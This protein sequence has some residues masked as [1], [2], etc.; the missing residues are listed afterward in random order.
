MEE[1]QI[2]QLNDKFLGQIIKWNGTQLRYEYRYRLLIK[3]FL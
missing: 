1:V 3:L 2:L